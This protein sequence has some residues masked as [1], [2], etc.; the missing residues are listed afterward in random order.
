MPK[1]CGA[2]NPRKLDFS[3]E[4]VR[5]WF[6]PCNSYRQS[7]TE[8]LCRSYSSDTVRCRESPRLVLIL[9]HWSFSSEHAIS[10][11]AS[12]FPTTTKYN[13][14]ELVI[15]GRIWFSYIWFSVKYFF[16]KKSNYQLR[17]FQEVV[18]QC[19][20]LVVATLRPCWKF[21]KY[22]IVKRQKDLNQEE[23]T[24]QISCVVLVLFAFTRIYKKSRKKRRLKKYERCR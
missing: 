5:N 2:I 8:N 7:T 6:L 10:K 24:N 16:G 9:A 13:W 18:W 3:C 4:V 11:L 23:Y 19:T 14:L 17:L 1:P 21:W 20:Q 12:K 22:L 15:G